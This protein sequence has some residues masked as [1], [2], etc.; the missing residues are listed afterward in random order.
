[1]FCQTPPEIISIADWLKNNVRTGE[2]LIIEA[3]SRDVFPSN[4]LI[5]SG[6]SPARCRL[7]YTPLLERRFVRNKE[8]F[9]KSILE[10]RPAYLVLNSE[11][12]LRGI[13]DFEWGR[14][15]QRLGKAMFSAVFDQEVPGYGKY[16]IYKC[17]Y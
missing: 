12:F 8:E 2:N 5:R 1:M 4:I 13:L 6:I 10:G 15:R 14:K 9:Q 16:I 3:D 7:L 11:G 17:S